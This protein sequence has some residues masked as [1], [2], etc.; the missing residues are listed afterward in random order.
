MRSCITVTAA[1]ALDAP[2]HRLLEDLER[3]T[4]YVGE[5]AGLG[6]QPVRG[7]YAGDEPAQLFA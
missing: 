7:F 6:H 2:C 1:I 5:R 4:G 3:G